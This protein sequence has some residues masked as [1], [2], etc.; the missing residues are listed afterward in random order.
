M[1]FWIFAIPFDI[2]GQRKKKDSP[3]EILKRRFAIGEITNDEY[4]EKKKILDS[5]LVKSLYK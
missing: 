4:H 5:D 1:I 3:L 2:P